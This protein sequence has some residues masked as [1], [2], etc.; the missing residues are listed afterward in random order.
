MDGLGKEVIS[1]SQRAWF[2]FVLER[3]GGYSCTQLA[4]VA[5]ASFPMTAR[6]TGLY[7]SSSSQ[8]TKGLLDWEGPSTSNN[9]GLQGRGGVLVWGAFQPQALSSPVVPPP[10][11]QSLLLLEMALGIRHSERSENLRP[12][13]IQSNINHSNVP[14]A[15]SRGRGGRTAGDSGC[16]NRSTSGQCS[17]CKG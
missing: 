5:P 2:T 12:R 16:Q 15:P 17:T 13:R 14:R 9:R 7:L 4:T 11:R 10:R 6:Q 3:S 8:D 1:S